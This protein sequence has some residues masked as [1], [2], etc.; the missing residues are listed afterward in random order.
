MVND[1]FT[2]WKQTAEDDYVNTPTSVLQYIIEMQR[3]H[4]GW[5]KT[6]WVDDINGEKYWLYYNE[7]YK[8]EL[9]T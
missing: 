9:N 1:N 3:I 7:T 8:E 5:K 2:Y 4:D 6:H